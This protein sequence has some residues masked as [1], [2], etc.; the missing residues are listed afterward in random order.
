[1][2]I[3]NTQ[4]KIITENNQQPTNY[5]KRTIGFIIVYG[6]ILTTIPYYLLEYSHNV[7]FLTYFSNVDIICNILAINFPTYFTDVYNISPNNIK[8]YLSYNIIS[9]IALSGIF[10]HGLSEKNRGIN[11]LIIFGSMI[12]MSIVTWTLPTQL[13]PYIVG[14]VKE[15]LKIKNIDYDILITT[16]TS[17]SFILFEAIIIHLYLIYYKQSNIHNYFKNYKFKL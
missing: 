16:L 11:D 14:V 12:I 6:L 13:I 5:I 1:M 3:D 9:L 4:N 10:I 8:Q 15:K 17:G 7:I 2:N